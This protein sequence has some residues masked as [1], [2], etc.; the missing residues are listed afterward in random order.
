MNLFSSSLN[1]VFTPCNSSFLVNVILSIWV[2]KVVVWPL[3]QLEQ[4]NIIRWQFS[5][6][7]LAEMDPRYICLWNRNWE[8]KKNSNLNYQCNATWSRWLSKE[9]LSNFLNLNYQSLGMFV[10]ETGFENLLKTLQISIINFLNANFIMDQTANFSK[11]RTACLNLKSQFS[12][13]KES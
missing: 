6:K 10:Y 7:T 4:T 12:N 11:N 9:D 1:L 13:P 2:C 8:F 3:A 5:G